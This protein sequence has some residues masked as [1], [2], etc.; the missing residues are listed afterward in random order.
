MKGEK[1]GKKTLR[2]N[3]FVPSNAVLMRRK[4][5]LHS[6]E[7]ARIFPGLRERGIFEKKRSRRAGTASALF[8]AA[9]TRKRFRGAHAMALQ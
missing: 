9:G 3:K 6:A 2:Q 7:N 5:N 4:C 8:G 1:S